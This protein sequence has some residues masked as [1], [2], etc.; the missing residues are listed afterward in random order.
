VYPDPRVSDFVTGN[1]V[2]SRI[3]VRKTPQLMER[4]NALWTPTIVLLD[5]A[6]TERYRFEGYVPAEDLLAH[7]TL[8][9]GHVAFAT[10]NF[11]EAQ[12]RFQEVLDKYP[13]S[14]VA[15]EALYW[16]GVARYKEKNDAAALGETASEFTRRYSDSSWAKKASVWAQPA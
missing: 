10:K 13:K 12:R 15:P 5:S 8:G 3:D 1:F 6:A 16:R 14:E 11:A 2:P 4:F 9:L 7:L